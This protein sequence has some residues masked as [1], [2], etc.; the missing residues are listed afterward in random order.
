MRQNITL[1][2]KI[3][4]LATLALL[5]IYFL[6][7]SLISGASFAAE[8]FARY[9]YFIAS[10]AAGF[11]IQMGLYAY[12]R[13]AATHRDPS[14]KVLAVTGT[15][16]T[17]AMISCCA[18]YAANILPILGVAGIATAIAEYQIEL[19]WVGL[20]M[21]IFGIAFIVRRINKFHHHEMA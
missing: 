2:I 18:H 21:N 8:Q 4:L 20:V 3:G 1:G 6:V 5:G 7:V 19:F 10:L 17:A 15:T 14:G 12:L 11:G 16:S 13:R 9:W